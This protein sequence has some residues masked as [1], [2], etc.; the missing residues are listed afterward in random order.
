MYLYLQQP[1]DISETALRRRDPHE[2]IKESEERSQA[3]DDVKSTTAKPD[4]PAAEDNYDK[5]IEV[6]EVRYEF[7]YIGHL[8]KDSQSYCNYLGSEKF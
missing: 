5:S 6:T 4:M 8:S 3:L 2:P 1:K 7:H